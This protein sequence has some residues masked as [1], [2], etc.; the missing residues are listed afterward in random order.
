MGGR[1]GL[2]LGRK[3][4]VDGGEWDRRVDEVELVG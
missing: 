4:G 1:V 2:G 3:L